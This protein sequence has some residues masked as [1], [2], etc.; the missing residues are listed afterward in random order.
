MIRLKLYVSPKT[1]ADLRQLIEPLVSYI[2][3][4]GRPRIA[5]VTALVILLTELSEIN[6]IAVSHLASLAE[7]HLG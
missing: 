6:E 1:E 3:A 7:N 4:V 2:S 5:L